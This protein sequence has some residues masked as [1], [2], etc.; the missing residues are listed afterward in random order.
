M[1]SPRRMKRSEVWAV[2]ITL[3]IIV[4]I[5]AVAIYQNLVVQQ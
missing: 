5:V 1:I 4:G 3:A 2:W